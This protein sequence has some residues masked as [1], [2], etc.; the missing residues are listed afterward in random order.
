[1]LTI[2]F[3][4][5]NFDGVTNFT[6]VNS[7]ENVVTL[8]WTMP[9]GTTPTPP[10]P[11]E[12]QWY[13]YGTD[14]VATGVGASGAF[15]WAVMFP[16]GSYEG[17]F[18]TKAATYEMSG[19]PFSGSVTIYNDGTNA[20][21]TAVGTMPVS[22]A[23]ATDQWAEFEFAEPIAID[24][25]KN[26]WI[27]FYNE[28]STSYPA[29]A[30]A[31]AGDPNA[32]WV[33][34]DGSSWMDLATAG[35]SG[36]SWMIK[37][38]VAQG[39]KG[40]VNEISVPTMACNNAGVLSSHPVR[41]NRNMWDLEFEF[42]GTSG[43][44]YGVASDGEYIYTSS[45][46]ASS[47]SMFYKYDLEGNFIEEFNIS[48]CGQLR[49]MTYDGEYFYGVAN[50]STIYCVDL[51]NHT[52]VSSTSSAYG[53]M[54]AITYDPERDGFWVVGNWSGAL[55]LVNRAGAIVTVGATPTSAS[56]CAYYK[57]PQGVEHVYCFNNG[58]NDVDDYN[59]ATNTITSA[60][61]N[62]N[63][64]PA[65]TGSSGGCFVG[66]YNGKTC[67]F[68]DIQQSP[69]HIA[70]YELDA[71]GPVPPTPVEG[72]IGAIIYRQYENEEPEC[73]GIF[74]YEVT[75]IMETLDIPGQ[76]TYTIKVI[77]AGEPDVTFFAMSCGETETVTIVDAVID[78]DEIISSIYP[79]PTSGDLHITATAMQHVT[80]FNTMG[81]VVYS[82]DVDTD[83][84]VLNMGQFE[85]GVY[86]IRVDAAEGSSVKRIAVVK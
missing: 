24:P 56:D 70:I 62:F 74:D 8:N 39:A 52:L 27:V 19:Y 54:R 42:D 26:L 31:D 81:Q 63:T 57:D 9:N 41:N 10:T 4:A 82:L 50:S 29:A 15:Y 6:A 7:D 84:F 35:L 76:Y 51:A 80:V 33:S 45:W 17:E 18:V 37:A 12:G 75:G 67:F 86:M 20:P 85:V 48:G 65:V 34:L 73:V 14:V 36:Y 71:E 40:E 25:T 44:Q 13:Q 28:T 77:Y 1:M 43:Y 55:T 68:G 61:F 2:F 69:Q 22:V 11:G 38:Y 64:N 32:R 59:I 23:G 5:F 72:V 3:H 66:A 49:G 83:E 21:A 78:N 16:A 79:N 46:S 60:V 53:A 47:T 58:T 30:C